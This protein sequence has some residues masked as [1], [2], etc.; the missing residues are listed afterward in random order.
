MGSKQLVIFAIGEEDFGISIEYVSII[1]KMLEIFK[2]PNTPDYIEGLVN[3]RGKVHTVVNLR[4][5]FKM[6]SPEF[7]EN[8]KIIMANTS[9]SI[10][11]IIVDEVKKIIKVEESEIEATP[12]ALSDMKDKFLSGVVKV[13]D[14]VI[15]LLDV[16]K[17][18]SVEELVKPAK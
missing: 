6:P 11:G 1:E 14:K 12:K 3:L 15:M 2:I 10:V 8:T 5:R 9:A 16:E 7:T 13:E 4:K 18:L 17:I